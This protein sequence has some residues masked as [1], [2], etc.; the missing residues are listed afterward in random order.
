MMVGLASLS[1]ATH[2]VPPSF[3]ITGLV[4][5]DRASAAEADP[6]QN[7][8]PQSGVVV[9][10]TGSPTVAAIAALGNSADDPT[11]TTG[12]LCALLAGAH[13]IAAASAISAL[14]SL[15]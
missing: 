8:A 12:M 6:V 14:Q 1:H 7:R 4:S 3:G 13:T 11:A 2:S 5:D 15:H 10:R 9:P